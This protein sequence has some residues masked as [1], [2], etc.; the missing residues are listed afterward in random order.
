MK[1]C[2]VNMVRQALQAMRSKRW[3]S[4]NPAYSMEVMNDCLKI[5]LEAKTP[6]EL[7]AEQ[8]QMREYL[9]IADNPLTCFG[10]VTK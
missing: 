8:K 9:C 2:L 1:I 4:M 5:L 6:E 3:D 7:L 10:H